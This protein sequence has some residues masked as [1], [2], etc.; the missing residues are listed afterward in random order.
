NRPIGSFLLLGPTGVGKTELAKALARTV[1]NSEKAM[2]RL[3]MSE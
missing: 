3:D 2:V 1:Y